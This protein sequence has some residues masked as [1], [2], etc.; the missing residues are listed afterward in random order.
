M[1]VFSAG[2]TRG[3]FSARLLFMLLTAVFF[4]GCGQKS[5]P[6]P[7]D[8][9]AAS[10][11]G[12]LA[13]VVGEGRVKLSWSTPSCD[14]CISMVYRFRQPLSEPFCPSCPIPFTRVSEVPSELS[15]GKE[16]IVHMERIDAG[17]RYI[18]KVNIHSAGAPG[19]DSNLVKFDY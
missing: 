13:H 3:R 8:R 14:D 5:F 2:N 12:D 16:K 15:G 10:A 17:Y 19:P 11:V 4:F 1:I 18:F 9:P 6:V 7:P